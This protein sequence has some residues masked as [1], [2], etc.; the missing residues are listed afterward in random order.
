MPGDLARER[1]SVGDD[2]VTVSPRFVGKECVYEDITHYVPAAA[3][4]LE[5]YAYERHGFEVYVLTDALSGLSQRELLDERYWPRHA[6]GEPR[7]HLPVTTC[8]GLRP[9][10]PVLWKATP[11]DYVWGTGV[12]LQDSKVPGTLYV[13]GPA[14]FGTLDFAADDRRCWVCTAV[15][16]NFINPAVLKA[17]FT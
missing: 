3:Y 9:G 7:Y 14:T 15:C 13:Q 6:T 17:D 10:M 16:S 8:D 5:F 12:V 11:C 1:W 4:R 2:T